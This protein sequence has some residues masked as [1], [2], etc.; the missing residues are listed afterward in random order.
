MRCGRCTDGREAAKDQGGRLGCIR[1]AQA[2]G[3][4]ALVDSL[5]HTTAHTLRQPSSLHRPTLPHPALQASHGVAAAHGPRRL[6]SFQQ[7]TADEALGQYVGF[8]VSLFALTAALP[9][10]AM[11]DALPVHSRMC[12]CPPQRPA[13][14]G[15]AATKAG[16]PTPACPAVPPI[17]TAGGPGG[18]CGAQP[19]LHHVSIGAESAAL[20]LAASRSMPCILAA[21][22]LLCV[23]AVPCASCGPHLHW[24]TSVSAPH[25]SRLPPSLPCSTAILIF[26]LQSGYIDLFLVD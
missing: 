26:T 13:C 19:L 1:N 17:H 14:P 3:C 2:C 24:T 9:A 5:L 20:L 21:A 25:P 12:C 23:L 15:Y 7:M 22:L 16:A 10:V 8:M 6:T 11:P 18:R 4:K